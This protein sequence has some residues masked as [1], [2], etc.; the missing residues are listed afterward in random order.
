MFAAFQLS[1][2]LRGLSNRENEF[3]QDYIELSKC[4]AAALAE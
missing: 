4:V 3:K 1:W 2:E